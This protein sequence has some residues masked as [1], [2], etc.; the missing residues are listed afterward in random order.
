MHAYKKSPGKIIHQLALINKT[1][2]SFLYNP[3]N[4]EAKKARG[5]RIKLT[6]LVLPTYLQLCF[7]MQLHN[8][9][10]SPDVTA[11]E[12]LHTSFLWTTPSVNNQS[13]QGV[14]LAVSDPKQDRLVLTIWLLLALLCSSNCTSFMAVSFPYEVSCA[15]TGKSTMN[16]QIPWQWHFWMFKD[17]DTIHFL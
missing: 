8:I 7:Q 1:W 14:K 17:P 10:P 13:H 3:L 16:F 9:Y 2:S 4:T 6:K 11:S 5:L 12:L 15:F